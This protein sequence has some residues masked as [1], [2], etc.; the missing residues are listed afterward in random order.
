MN[1]DSL[2]PDNIKDPKHREYIIHLHEIIEKQN[3]EI[4]LNNKIFQ[5]LNQN[6]RQI[7]KQL[8]NELLVIFWDDPLSSIRIIVKKPESQPG[9][10]DLTAG[11]GSN[12][13]AYAYLDGQVEDQLGKPGILYISD[14]AKIHS[15]K[16][17]SGNQF[18]KTILGVSLGNEN[19]NLGM[20]WFAFENQKNFTKFESDSLVSLVEACTTVIQ[21]CIEWNENILKL[22]F[23]NEILDLVN[24]PIFIISKNEI[25]FSNIS[26]KQGFHK[27][28]DNADEKE[29]IIRKIWELIIENNNL[30]TLNERVYQVHLVESI[31]NIQK[32][33][34]AAILID[35]TLPQ[36]QR[37]YVSLVINSL[38]Q[39]LRSPLN[40]ILGSIK[41]L[42]L[43]GN[44]NQH[45]KD[46]INSIQQKTEESLKIV[47][48][49]LDLERII[50]NNGLKIQAESLQSLVGISSSLI[51]HFAKQK[52]ISIINSI[53]NLDE[54][55]NVDK[56][57]F[58]QA[59]A[60]IFE[61][62]IKQTRLDGEIAFT[63]DKNADKWQIEIRDNSNGLSQVEVDRLNSYE[64]LHE[65]PP[66]L[67]LV[68]RIINF[69]GGTFKVQSDLGKGNTYLIEIP[70]R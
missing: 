42:P 64:N 36:K 67:L 27:L 18:P 10:L 44:V 45:Q 15:I 1:K 68:R 11:I 47:G 23:Q 35:E 61:F 28:L 5:I 69:H 31:Q 38:S 51:N 17:A 54:V 65:V 49:L 34:R 22:F 52:R 62:A 24:S 63:A 60:N 20:I 66:S 26:A 7:L 33:F 4:S 25:L 53:S 57:L 50:K 46:Y 19:D 40:L 70:N 41:M 13:E 55:I 59:I 48:D 9:D 43:V 12:Y 3:K 39:G 16:F 6:Y 29:N 37:D 58:T 14:T 21:R 56:V 30:I 8:L 2:I 32:S